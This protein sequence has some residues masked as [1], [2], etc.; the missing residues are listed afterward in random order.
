MNERATTLF[1]LRHALLEQTNLLAQFCLRPTW[2]LQGDVHRRCHRTYAWPTLSA[3]DLPSSFLS[4]SSSFSSAIIFSSRPTTTS[5]NFSRS[6]IFSCSS[7]L[8][9]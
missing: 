8:D 9:S 1:G 6:R 2:L 5:S 7:A 3:F 4:T